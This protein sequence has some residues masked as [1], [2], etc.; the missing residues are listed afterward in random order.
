MIK[1]KDFVKILLRKTL[2]APLFLVP[3]F[4][5]GIETEGI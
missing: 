1:E 4:E 3:H 2:N 5:R